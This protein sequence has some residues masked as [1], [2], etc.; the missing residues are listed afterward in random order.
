MGPDAAGA[1]G[2]GPDPQEYRELIGIGIAAVS[3]CRHCTYF[4]TQFARVFGATEAEI[5]DAVHL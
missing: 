2:R 1:D 4:H 3:K 5:E